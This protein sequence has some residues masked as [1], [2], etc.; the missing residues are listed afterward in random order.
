MQSR[1]RSR[2]CSRRLANSQSSGVPDAA[3]SQTSDLAH[4]YP[5]RRREQ[6]DPSGHHGPSASR[7]HPRPAV[8]CRACRYASPDTGQGRLQ[9]G[10]LPA[11]P[12][13]AGGAHRPDPCGKPGGPGRFVCDRGGRR[14]TG[15]L[16]VRDS[17][18]LAAAA[19]TRGEPPTR[20]RRAARGVQSGR[21]GSTSG[22]PALPGARP[23]Q[24]RADAR[25]LGSGSGRLRSSG[26]GARAPRHTS[27]TR[28]RVTG[29]R[30]DMSPR[31]FG[32][33]RTHA[34]HCGKHAPLC[35]TNDTL[36]PA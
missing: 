4:L 31:P 28:R 5:A 30:R 15:F 36:W 1:H 26:R 32:F 17:R 7:R 29:R 21:P 11:R 12:A 20:P 33:G 35:R 23:G 14:G 2:S 6:N 10:D 3:R 25:A 9:V 24:T 19:L 13:R 27:G 8:C 22:D 18:R 34:C 16:G